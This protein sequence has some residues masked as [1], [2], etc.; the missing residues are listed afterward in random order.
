MEQEFAEVHI[1]LGAART[2]QINESW[3]QMFGGGVK[4]IMSRLFGGAKVPVKIS[5]SRGEIDAFQR[6]IAGEKQYIQT[7]AK[8][9]LD[10]PRTY[11]NKYA[12]RKSINDFERATGLKWPMRG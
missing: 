8:Y 12:L 3:M 6:A 5:G 10:D 2:G 7:A 9:G 1:D 11:K 4:M